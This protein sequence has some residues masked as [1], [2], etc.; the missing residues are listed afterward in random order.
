MNSEKFKIVV[1][2]VFLGVA[3]VSRKRFKKE[4][5]DHK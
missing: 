2:I 1:S 4:G 5:G 3:A